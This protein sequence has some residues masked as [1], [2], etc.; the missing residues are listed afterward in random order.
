M[1]DR[2]VLLRFDAERTVAAFP[3]LDDA[4]LADVNPDDAA[5]AVAADAVLVTPLADGGVGAACRKL[6][7]LERNGQ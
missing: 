7:I 3:A 5:T 6:R 2:G 1:R 4:L